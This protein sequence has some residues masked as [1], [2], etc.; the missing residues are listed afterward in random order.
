MNATVLEG[1]RAVLECLP[2][3][4]E[5]VVEWLREGVPLADAPELAARCDRADNG[6]LVIR[7]ATSTD[8]GE[9]ECRVRDPAGLTQSASAFLDVQCEC[10]SL[11]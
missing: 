7:S 1:A 11:V 2:K 8:P 10:S 6:S 5:S 3:S 9:Y 4:Q